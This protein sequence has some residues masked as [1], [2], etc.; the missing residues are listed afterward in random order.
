MELRGRQADVEVGAQ[1]PRNVRGKDLTQALAGD[2]PDHFADQVA[3]PVALFFRDGVWQDLS[4]NT[5]FF[6][7]GGA[8]LWPGDWGSLTLPVI[9]QT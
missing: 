6:D 7:V 9:S 8:P 3:V 4:R 5:A 2:A 1:R